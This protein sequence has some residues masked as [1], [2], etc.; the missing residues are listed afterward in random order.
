[1]KRTYLAV[2]SSYQWVDFFVN[3]LVDRKAVESTPRY[4]ML[5]GDTN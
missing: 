5:A 3:L 4:N 2:T 1:M